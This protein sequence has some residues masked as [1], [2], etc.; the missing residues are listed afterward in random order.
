M[1]DLISDET[2]TTRLRTV[3]LPAE[4][5]GWALILEPIALGLL[6][7]PSFRGLCIALAAFCCFLARQPLKLALSDHIKQRNLPRTTSG[8]RQQPGAL[9]RVTV[10]ALQ[11]GMLATVVFLAWQRLVPVLAIVGFVVLAIRAAKGL[12]SFSPVAPKK[13][14]IAEFVFGA[15]TVATVTVGYFLGW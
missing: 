15:F 13:L 5:G 10:I 12:L 3:A 4:H 7:A 1:R 2:Q 11:I 14:G 6:V 9:A 8:R